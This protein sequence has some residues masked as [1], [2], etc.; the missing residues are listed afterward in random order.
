MLSFLAPAALAGLALLAI[1]IAIHLFKPRKVRVTPFSSLRWLDLS[2]QKLARR[3]RWHQLLLFIVRAT[4]I[5]LLVFALARPLFST[6]D[7]TSGVD[8][9]IVLDNSP[10]MTHQASVDD[11]TQ[12]PLERGKAAAATLLSTTGDDRAALILTSH[13]ARALGPLS[14]DSQAALRQLATVN[15]SHGPTQLAAALDTIAPMLRRSPSDRPMEITFITDN[16]QQAWDPGVIHTFMAEAGRSVHVSLVDVSTPGSENA[17][18]VPGQV[19]AS[20][21]TLRVGVGLAGLRSS[22]RSVTL[23]GIDGLAPLKQDVTL[24]PGQTQW[25]QF[26]LP[27]QVSL[28][29]AMARVQLSPADGLPGDDT[30][31]LALPSQSPTN[32]LLV[33]PASNHPAGSH[34]SLHL[35]AALAALI[36]DDPQRGT[37]TTRTTDALTLSDLQK[38]QVVFLAGVPRL[39]QDQL[40]LLQSRVAAGM[41][42]AVFLGPQVDVSFYNRGLYNPLD[43]SQSLLPFE[44]QAVKTMALDNA[45]PT[46]L[47]HL[48]WDHPLLAPLRDPV[49]GDL[50]ESRFLQA[51]TFAEPASPSPAVTI[52][53]RLGGQNPLLIEKPMG[54]GKV[55]LFNTTADDTWS[56]LPR[57]KSFLPLIDQTLQRLA[58]AATQRVFEV[59]EPAII[60]IAAAD[61]APA[62]YTVLAPD[63]QRMEPRTDRQDQRV[64]IQIDTLGQAGV[65]R[66]MQDQQEV[67]R[68]IA[69]PDV[70]ESLLTPGDVEVLRQWW[71]PA[72][73]TLLTPQELSTQAGVARRNTRLWPWL[74]AAGGVLLVLEMYLVHR[75]CP[76]MN[77]QLAPSLMGQPRHITPPLQSASVMSASQETSPQT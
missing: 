47:T 34:P 67:S 72:S 4:F 57:R 27:E 51:M 68:F 71:S 7:Q 61:E 20:S 23:D 8:R 2:K 54:L 38:A 14:A 44:L 76:R 29:G 25:L 6:G 9:F 18:L 40:A 48:R 56:D 22:S 5:L 17:Y 26:T 41:G 37:L 39:T 66:V 46:G 35:K 50:P 30:T 70:R 33:E 65:Y 31:W 60:T 53:A 3:I 43:P 58:G 19:N 36:L 73:L 1:P 15:V 64:M 63:G 10:S 49:L 11:P 28:E 75:L 42:L 52:L 59:G 32:I 12:T 62:G 74:L 21:R 13:R 77:P 55:I 45:Q 16:Q 69:L 24:T